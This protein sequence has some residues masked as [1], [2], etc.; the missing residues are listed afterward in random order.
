MRA[1]PSGAWRPVSCAAVLACAASIAFA[2]A[3]GGRS[4]RFLRDSSADRVVST[5][6][7][8]THD[9]VRIERAEPGAAP[10]LHPAV[11]PSEQLRALLV[12]LR[13]AVKDDELFTADELDVLA[14]ALAKALAQAEPGQDVA[15][16]VTGRHGGFGPL[17]PRTV[18]T[19][20]VFRSADGLQL[21]AGMVWAPFESQYLATGVRVAFEPGRRAA[22]VDAGVRIAAP[23][24]RSVRADW[25]SLLV[26]PAAA[27]APRAAT[28]APAAAAPVAPAAAGA[29]VPPAAAPAPA[30]QRPRDA[31]F[32]EDQ[33]QRLRTLKRLHD[34]GLITDEEYRQKRYEV[35]QQL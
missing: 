5:V 17:V 11:V 6:L 32:Y 16:A 26:A 15:F 22:P 21:I 3:P 34:N 23:N 7:A 2:Q 4:E 9:Y 29:A 31:G 12:P 14:P 19:G 35:L 30:P 33:E 25:V 24:G 20:R 27:P 13:N 1:F 10:S 18:T 8:A 28:T